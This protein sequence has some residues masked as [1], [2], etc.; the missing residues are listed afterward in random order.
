[1][2]LL[3]VSVECCV[4][5]RLSKSEAGV[6]SHPVSL[7]HSLSLRLIRMHPGCLSAC[8]LITL[9]ASGPN[10]KYTVCPH[11][12]SQHKVLLQQKPTESRM[13]HK[14]GHRSWICLLLAGLPM[15]RVFIYCHHLCKMVLQDVGLH[16]GRGQP[17]GRALWKYLCWLSVL[18]FNKCECKSINAFY[19]LFS[20]NTFFI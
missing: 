17:I 11:L 7:Y 16:V 12:S 1:M 13:T 9:Q 10:T 6:S 5:F 15:W 4:G 3:M 18:I 8:S 2:H 20:D 14:Q 19:F